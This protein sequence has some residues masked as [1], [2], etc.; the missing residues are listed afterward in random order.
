MYNLNIETRKFNVFDEN[1]IE[2]E[3]DVFF[4]SGLKNLAGLLLFAFTG[5]KFLNP[6]KH[7]GGYFTYYPYVTSLDSIQK[8]HDNYNLSLQKKLIEHGFFIEHLSVCDEIKM[9]DSMCKK[10]L[11]WL[12]ESSEYLIANDLNFMKSVNGIE[13]LGA[14]PLFPY[15]SLRPI[16]IVRVKRYFNYEQKIN[17]YIKVAK[18]LN[19]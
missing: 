2:S 11:K 19:R 7:V 16:H 3:F 13:E 10:V 4:A 8:E 6:S 1:D 5:A 15:F 12:Y 17:N 18:R 9:S 14:D